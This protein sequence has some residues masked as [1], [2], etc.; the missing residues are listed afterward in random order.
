MLVLQAQAAPVVQ[1]LLRHPHPTQLATAPTRLQQQLVVV[2]QGQWLTGV[3]SSSI[4]Q[5]T[6]PKVLMTPRYVT[7]L[8]HLMAAPLQLQGRMVLCTPAPACVPRQQ[9]LM[10]IMRGTIQQQQ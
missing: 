9:Q 8:L 2:Q 10:M 7:P 4:L 6:W 5:T 1:P 3:C